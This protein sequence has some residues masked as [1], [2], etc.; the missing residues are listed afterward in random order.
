MGKLMNITGGVV[1][2]VSLS[3]FPEYSQQYVQRLGGAVDELTTVVKDFDFSAQ[4]SGMSRQEAL[5]K[6]TGTEFLNRRQDDMIR[7][8]A[9]HDYLR[10]SYADLREANAFRRLASIQQFGDPQ[11][12]KGAWEDFQPAIPLSLESLSLLLLGYSG[13]FLSTSWVGRLI[14]RLKRIFIKEKRWE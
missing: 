12:A 2:G 13:G 1:L 4:Q 11:V 9:R 14:A 5:D 6:M 10:T 8:F 7:T 3:Q